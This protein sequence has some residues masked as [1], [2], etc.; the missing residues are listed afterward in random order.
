MAAPAS[1]LG[2]PDERSPLSDLS[3]TDAVEAMRRGDVTAEAY[4]GALLDRASDRS[5]LNAFITLDRERVLEA[6]RAADR[7]RSAGRADGLLHGLPIPVKDSVDTRAL[8]TSIGTRALRGFLPGK[9]A[10]LV[11]RLRAAGAL[12]MG[13]TNLT[14][15]SFGWTS[16]N[17][18]FGAV[19]NPYDRARIPG[20]SSGGSA[21]AVAAR[22]APLAVGAD[23]LGSIQIPAA[24]C[25]VAGLRPT[26]GRYPGEGV[27]ALA[28]DELDQVG[29]LARTVSDLALFD[30]AITGTTDAIGRK[31][32]RGVRLGVAP[33][34][35]G[36]LDPDV[37]RVTRDA[38]RRL[39]EA[40]AVLVEADVSEP[41]K[42]AFDVAATIM[43][44]ETMP[45][46]ARFLK[47]QGTGLTID[48]VLAQVDGKMR[49]FIE[50]HAAG[51]HR[52]SREVYDGILNTRAEVK[53]AIAR[54]FADQGIAALAFPAAAAL[55]PLIG[56]EGAVISGRTV[57]LFAAFGRNTA[58]SPAGG[59]PALVLPAGLSA[60]GLPISLEFV[61]PVG[62]D[63]D[64]LS[65][66]AS[67]EIA[68]GTIPAPLP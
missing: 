56:E 57:S 68:L 53:S 33:F 47:E 16:D 6:A 51:A 41:M 32:L 19:H 59:L 50:A 3:A 10:P 58:L 26:F 4:A 38:M 37:E 30:A 34:Y 35:W 39:R 22:M 12:V 48:E 62:Q 64:L 52:P 60:G 24:L 66:G 65:L 15:L 45:S 11:E 18:T 8:P 29:P 28:R 61:A 14:E 49:A 13:K 46:I 67:F 1:G 2:A 31:P 17:G 43:L 7:A 54:H 27:F 63:R 20:G 25:G 23:S 5:A 40:G 36:D 21:A 9:D 42:A 55:P 44:H